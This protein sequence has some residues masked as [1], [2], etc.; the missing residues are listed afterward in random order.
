MPYVVCALGFLLAAWLYYW[1]TGYNED[2][3]VEIAEQREETQ[4]QLDQRDI[5]I[6]DL[7]LQ[8][9]EALNAPV[10]VKLG[11]PLPETRDYALGRAALQVEVAAWDIDVRPDGKGLPKG[12]GD[13]FTGEEVFSENCAT[14]HGDFGEAVDRWPVLAGGHDTLAEE[15]P[16]KTIGSYWPYLSTVYDYVYRAMPF[17]NAQSLSHD[18]VYA[19]TAYLLYVNDLVEDD[20]ELSHE[21]FGSI[22]LPNEK[23]FYPDDRATTEYAA[24][25]GE[26]CMSDC[27]Q[28]VE[29]TA[30]AR[31]IDVTPEEEGAEK[32]EVAALDTDQAVSS[33]VASG[34]RVFR[35]CRSCHEIGASARNKS[36]PQLTGILG[37]KF[38]SLDNFNY[39]SAFKQAASEE[40]IWD[41]ASMAAF[42]AKPKGYL[43]G[44]KMGF[45]GLKKQEDLDAIIAYLKSA[46][47]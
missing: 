2:K 26:P 35:K 40:R 24:F 10:P 37:R 27:K 33:L 34:E 46:G 16:V 20:F 14:C 19:I 39:S 36:G 38:G 23:N 25:T 30:R 32:Q 4:R 1:G 21:N 41:E 13:V 28:S 9:R 31:V 45:A 3:F 15:D 17:G 12:R 43:P 18:D 6:R 44:T 22:S 29:I 47:E 7:N 11:D 42:L 8:I 5:K